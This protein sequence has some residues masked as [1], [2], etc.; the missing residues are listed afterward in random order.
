MSSVACS[1]AFHGSQREWASVGGMCMNVSFL[2]SQTIAFLSSQSMS[3]RVRSIQVGYCSPPVTVPGKHPT[4]DT[5]RCYSRQGRT[6]LQV[7]AFVLNLSARMS[8]KAVW[9][10]LRSLG[11]SKPVR[12]SH[13]VQ[14]FLSP[15]TMSGE[16]TEELRRQASPRATTSSSGNRQSTLS[17]DISSSGTEMGKGAS[18]RYPT[19]RR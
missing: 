10:S 7:V 2:A 5:S 3:R 15:S 9:H 8:F 16:S 6:G 13:M 14:V 17:L 18:L 4:I 11:T 1:L 19:S 12:K